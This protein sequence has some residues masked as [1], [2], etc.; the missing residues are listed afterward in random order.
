MLSITLNPK[1]LTLDSNH[2][3]LPLLNCG[4]SQLVLSMAAHQGDHVSASPG[5][6]SQGISRPDP[7]TSSGAFG[8]L[9]FRGL[10]FRVSGLGLLGFPVAGFRVQC[11][12]Y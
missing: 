5:L 8:G 9:G 3:S 2:K 1:L 6:E 11:F 7:T 12:I 10:G 4:L